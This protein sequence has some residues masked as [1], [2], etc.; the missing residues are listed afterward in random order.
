LETLGL[1]ERLGRDDPGGP[2][3]DSIEEQDAVLRLLGST[4]AVLFDFDGPICDLF[5]GAPTDHVAEQVKRAARPV[6]TPLDPQVEAC[7]DSHGILRRLRDMYD[8][9][10]PGE[11]DPGPLARAEEIVAEFEAQAVP[12]AHMA[13]HTD[14]LVNRLRDLGVQLVIVS[15]NAEGPIRAY[16][17]LNGLGPAFAGVFGRDPMDAARMKPDPD[18]VKRALEHLRLPGSECLLVGDQITDLKAARSVGALFLGYT[19]DDVRKKEMKHCGAAAVVSSHLPLIE[20]A[21]KLI[22]IRTGLSPVVP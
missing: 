15:N 13:P 19:Q 7:G 20:A 3:P 11:L 8:R 9:R 5:G 14:T 6:W 21:E 10:P 16:L 17:E 1:G 12:H 18:C 2:L 22:T 4:Q